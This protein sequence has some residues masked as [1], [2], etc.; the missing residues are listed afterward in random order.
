MEFEIAKTQSDYFG[1]MNVRN[2]VF[3]VEQH[4]DS[5]EELDHFDQSA[6][7]FVARDNRSVIATCRLVLF[8]GYAKLGRMAVLSSYRNQH[9][10]SQL[11]Q[12]V[13]STLPA[14]G[15]QTIRLGAQLTAIP[16]YERLGFRTYGDIFLDAN[17]EH[18]MME[19]Q[20]E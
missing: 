8:E 16:F 2:H 10:G 20:Y 17:I 12:F 3:V 4:V 11:I 15:I 18:K 14:H 7:H 13:E 5:R 6:I 9:I 1:L 19:K